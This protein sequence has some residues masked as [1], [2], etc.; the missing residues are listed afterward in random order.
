MIFSKTELEELQRK[1]QEPGRVPARNAIVDRVLPLPAS[2]AAKKPAIYSLDDPNPQPE[3]AK[4]EPVAAP[5][6]IKKRKKLIKTDFNT[7][8]VTV[9]YVDI[10]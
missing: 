2:A 1:T 3:V 6:L 8:K 5:V 4:A 7:G 10:N 9:E